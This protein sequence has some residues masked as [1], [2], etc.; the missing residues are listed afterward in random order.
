MERVWSQRSEAVLVL[1]MEPIV[2]VR[3][4]MQVQSGRGTEFE[5]GNGEVYFGQG[6]YV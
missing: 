5:G 6:L 3:F 2:S 1:S 4:D